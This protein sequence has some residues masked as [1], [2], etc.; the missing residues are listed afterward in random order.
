MQRH[1]NY[2]RN[3]WC[4]YC[5]TLAVNG[6]LLAAGGSIIPVIL[7]L[8]ALILEVV[9]SAKYVK[10]LVKNLVGEIQKL[11]NGK[12]HK[13]C[14]KN[15]VQICPEIVGFLV[16]IVLMSGISDVLKFAKPKGAKVGKVCGI[17]TLSQTLKH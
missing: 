4:N 1:Q 17:Q 6:A 10:G 2:C 7:K 16:Q 15:L 5:P 8:G 11:K 13:P 3:D 12:C 14:K 9:T